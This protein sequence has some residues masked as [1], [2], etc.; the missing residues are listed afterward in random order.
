MPESFDELGGGASGEES[1]QMDLGLAG[2][3]GGAFGRVERVDRVVA[4]FDVGIGAELS[5]DFYGA[6]VGENGDGIHAAKGCQDTG[7]V[8]FAIDW[9]FRAF[10]LADGGIAVEG[11]NKEVAVGAGFLEVLDMARVEEVEAAIGEDDAKPGEFLGIAPGGE[12]VQ[13]ENGSGKTHGRSRVCSIIAP[14][15]GEH[16][17]ASPVWPE[18]EA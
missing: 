5:D 1:D 6:G 12:F 17:Q 4:A 15:A 18:T 8:V 3:E 13:A 14:S 10:E 7:A 2:F 9:A 11:Y 16:R